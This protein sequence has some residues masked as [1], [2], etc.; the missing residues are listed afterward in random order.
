MRTFDKHILI[1]NLDD[2]QKLLDQGI[3]ERTTPTRKCLSYASERM[4]TFTSNKHMNLIAY[5]YPYE[6]EVYRHYDNIL[7]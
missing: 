4:L 7:H 6:F 1:S 3:L 5:A 2:F